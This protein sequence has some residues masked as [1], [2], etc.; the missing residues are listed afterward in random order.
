[1]G[2]PWW[3]SGKE[4]ICNAGNEGLIHGPERFPGE[5]NGNPLQDSCLGNLMNRTWRATVQGAAESDTIQQL[6][7]NN[8]YK[9]ICI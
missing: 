6:S 3:L 5:G 4:S 2:F 7:N 8:N 1:M 9:M